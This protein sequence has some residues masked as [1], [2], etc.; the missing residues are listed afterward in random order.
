MSASMGLGPRFDAID[1]SDTLGPCDPEPG[2]PER[3]LYA[4]FHH[5]TGP[6]MVLTLKRGPGSTQV[7]WAAN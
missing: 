4:I 6:T 3:R 2:D 5:E 7:L 1:F